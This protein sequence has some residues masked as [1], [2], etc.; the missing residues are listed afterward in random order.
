M[1]FYE[2]E[3]NNFEELAKTI[4]Y[5]LL[6]TMFCSFPRVKMASIQEFLF[7]ELNSEREV[8]MQDK[9]KGRKGL[10]HSVY[11]IYT[12]ILIVYMLG[13]VLSHL[14]FMV[15]SC[16]SNLLLIYRQIMSKKNS[17]GITNGHLLSCELMI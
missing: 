2:Q 5:I 12:I 10:T 15:E 7:M 9:E 16:S 11:L 6:F 17:T 3:K 4:F 13:K 14:F 1:W 8:K